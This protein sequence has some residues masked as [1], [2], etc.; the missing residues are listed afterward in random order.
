[1]SGARQKEGRRRPAGR[2]DGCAGISRLD[3]SRHCGVAVRP[4]RLN[5]QCQHERNGASGSGETASGGTIMESGFAHAR[6]A[7]DGHPLAGSRR[8]WR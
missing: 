6:R 2:S 5:Y 3:E 8:R 4:T 1:M 7:G